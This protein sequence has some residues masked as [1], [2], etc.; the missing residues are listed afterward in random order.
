MIGMVPELIIP[1]SSLP[2]KVLN[3]PLP[4]FFSKD[5]GV[6]LPTASLPYNDMRVVFSFRS[7]G[8]LLTTYIDNGDDGWSA[9]PTVAS[10]LKSVPSLSTVQVWG[11]YA[12]VSNDHRRSMGS[13]P[14][15]IVIE[16]CQASP[17]FTYDPYRQP[18]QSFDI[19]FSHAVKALFWGV[20]NTTVP[21]V[22]ANYTT[23]SAKVSKIGEEVFIDHFLGYD[24][25]ETTTLIYE[26]T[27]RLAALGSDYFSL[28]QPYYQPGMV[29]PAQTGYHMYS[30]ALNMLEHN[31]TGSTN[32]GKLTNISMVP[33]ASQAAITASER[34]EKFQ[35]VVFVLNNN[36]IRISGGA[37][38][39]PVL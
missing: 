22:H 27:Q 3:I 4:L 34:G 12:L 6:A 17:S 39:F 18:Y 23:E 14:R 30:Y 21:S 11:N 32:Y 35:F 15:D 9:A 28:V 31:P 29:I 2:S 13:V 5:S 38:G 1:S 19:R 10:D 16:Q 7:L 33:A 24:P 37:L 36:L 20:Q 25:I 26:N 8:E